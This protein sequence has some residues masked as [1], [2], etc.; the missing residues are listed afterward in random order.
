MKTKD[1]RDWR[2]INDILSVKISSKNVTELGY[3][4]TWRKTKEEEL[5]IILSLFVCL[6]INCGVLLTLICVP[7]KFRFHLHTPVC[8]HLLC[9]MQLSLMVFSAKHWR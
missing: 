9:R 5:I 3:C 7:H 2:I 6:F 8:L 1:D 4:H